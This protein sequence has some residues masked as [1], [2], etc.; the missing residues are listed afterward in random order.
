MGGEPLPA[1]AAFLQVR[2]QPGRQ[3]VVE[4]ARGQVRQVAGN[5]I[6]HHIA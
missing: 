4:R 2:A 6:V 1:L 3:L 5:L